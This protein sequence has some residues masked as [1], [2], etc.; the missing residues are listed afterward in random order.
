[1]AGGK[2]AEAE[3]HLDAGNQRKAFNAF[4]DAAYNP[5]FEG[6]LELVLTVG[7]RMRHRITEPKYAA[8]WDSA[9]SRLEAQL[10]QQ[11]EVE[12][13]SSSP[14]VSAETPPPTGHAAPME[15]P[16]ASADRRTTNLATAGLTCWYSSASFSPY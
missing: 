6:G 1:M 11:A 10:A 15:S 4:D 9:L 2:L 3:R 14:T 7:C 12:P 16:V 5:G 8:K 13:A